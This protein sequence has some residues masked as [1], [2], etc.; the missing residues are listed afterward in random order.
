MADSTKRDAILAV[1]AISLTAVFVALLT[2]ILIQLLIPS[3]LRDPL[4]KAGGLKPEQDIH[5]NK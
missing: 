2:W 5:R 1:A 4:T 3:D